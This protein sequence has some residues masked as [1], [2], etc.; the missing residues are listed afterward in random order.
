MSQILIFL[1]TLSIQHPTCECENRNAWAPTLSIH[2]DEYAWTTEQRFIAPYK[3]GNPFLSWGQFTK[4]WGV[5]LTWC[6]SD[7][8][9]RHFTVSPH[10]FSLFTSGVPLP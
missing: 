7:E 8:H 6:G 3:Y 2:A 4:F 10:G 9:M 1:L 5:T